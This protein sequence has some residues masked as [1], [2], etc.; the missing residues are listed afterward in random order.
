[1]KKR[2]ANGI[3]ECDIVEVVLVQRKFNGSA[4]FSGGDFMWGTT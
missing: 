1:M 3:R 2:Y 4:V